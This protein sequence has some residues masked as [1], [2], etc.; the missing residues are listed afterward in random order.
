MDSGRYGT[1]PGPA[2]AISVEEAWGLT[3]AEDDNPD[4]WNRKK[5]T[6]LADLKDKLSNC[7]LLYTSPSPR[8]S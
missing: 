5:D 1:T 4:G 2:T 6:I 7:C 3:Q 8:D